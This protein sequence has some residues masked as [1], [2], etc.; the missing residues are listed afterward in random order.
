MTGFLRPDTLAVSVVKDFASLATPRSSSQFAVTGFLGPD[1]LAGLVVKGFE[2]AR[3]RLWETVFTQR[4]KFIQYVKK[5][6]TKV[7]LQKYVL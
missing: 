4:A 5:C 2:S 1:T 6:M 3:G 7:F